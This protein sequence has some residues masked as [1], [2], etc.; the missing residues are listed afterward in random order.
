MGG[1]GLIF[2]PSPVLVNV[3][4]NVNL[5]YISLF[6]AGPYLKGETFPMFEQLGDS[7]E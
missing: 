7:F 6:T 5:P 4:R 2:T 1:V 3:D